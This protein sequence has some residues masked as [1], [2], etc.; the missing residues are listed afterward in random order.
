M[1][2]QSVETNQAF[3]RANPKVTVGGFGD[4]VDDPAG[5]SLFRA[6]EVANVLR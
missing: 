6:P 3:L 5:K 1:E 2:I 4:R